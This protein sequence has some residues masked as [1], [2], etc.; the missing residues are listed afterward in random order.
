MC[1]GQPDLPYVS[2]TCSGRKP[3]TLMS[4]LASA[5][6][7]SLPVSWHK[8]VFPLCQVSNA[9]TVLMPVPVS[10]ASTS[11]VLNTQQKVYTLIFNTN[12]F[13][14]FCVPVW[15]QL[16][17]FLLP[18]AEQR[19]DHSVGHTTVVN[20]CKN[21]SWILADLWWPCCTIAVTHR[22]H[23]RLVCDVDRRSNHGHSGS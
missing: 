18:G 11:L 10:D 17:V 7:Y 4:G 1:L 9:S 16:V 14:V 8:G 15:H 23:H 21:S 3:L 6:L 20:R 22:S 5:F 2:C 12:L 19:C 13:H